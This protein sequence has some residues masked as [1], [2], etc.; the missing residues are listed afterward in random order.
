[1]VDLSQL[2]LNDAAIEE[3]HEFEVDI[4]CVVI[5]NHGYALEGIQRA[6]E[7]HIANVR[8]SLVEEDWDFVNPEIRHAE[9]F[10]EGLRRSA[11][12]L[13]VVGLVTR[14]Q[15]WTSRFAKRAKIGKPARIHQSQLLNQ[16]E[17]LNK[18]L[19]HQIV[20]VTF[21]RELVDVR[22]SVVHAN[23]QA[24]W[25]YPE[26]C[27]RQVAQHH[28][29]PWSEV[30]FSAEQLKEAVAKTIQQVKWYDENIRTDDHING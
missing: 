1:M 11:N 10:Y 23:S 13:A 27:N 7:Q 30:E 21:F 16:M 6:E 26:G 9:T 14:L 19:G 5:A 18:L 15:H 2:N 29:S 4:A 12:R 8:H 25:E 24:E 22:D 17:A 20:A 3:S 28:R